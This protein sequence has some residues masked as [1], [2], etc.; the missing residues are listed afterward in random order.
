MK[1]TGIAIF[2]LGVVI[3]L[4]GLIQ[5]MTMGSTTPGEGTTQ[6]LNPIPSGQTYFPISFAFTMTAAALLIGG[7]LWAYGG[8]GTVET[9]NPAVRN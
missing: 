3:G 2:C 6:P 8:K 9:R 4:F 1:I 7:L 5:L